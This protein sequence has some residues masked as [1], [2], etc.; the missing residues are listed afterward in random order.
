MSALSRVV[1]PAWVAPETEDAAAVAHRRPQDRGTVLADGAGRDET[2]EIAVGRQELADIDRPVAARDVGDD[3][4]EAAPVG[5]RG[6]DERLRQVDAPPRGVQHALDHVTDLGVGQRQRKSLRHSP[7]S[8]EHAVR[9]IDPYLFDRGIVEVGLKRT[10]PRHRGEHLAHA[11]RLVVDGT[12]PAGEGEIIVS[13]H[14]CA[15]DLCRELRIARRVGA[16]RPQ[17]LSHAL[18]DDEGGRGGRGEGR[19]RSILASGGTGIRKLST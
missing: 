5:Q 14:L 10:V 13:L 18:G 15:G 17:P 6:I 16:L 3:H 7:A 2:V 4:M 1:L 9:S 19:H 8:G 11:R 12:E